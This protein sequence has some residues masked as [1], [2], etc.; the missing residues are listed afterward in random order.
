MR[1]YDHHYITFVMLVIQM[2][3]DDISLPDMIEWIPRSNVMIWEM[4]ARYFPSESLALYALKHHLWHILGTMDNRLYIFK[5]CPSRSNTYIRDAL[6]ILKD[7]GGISYAEILDINNCPYISDP[8]RDVLIY[9]DSIMKCE[10]KRVYDP[11][12]L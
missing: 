5:T 10:D 12:E 9:M 6:Q 4:Y 1:R 11:M 2:N 8:D 7:C 3:G